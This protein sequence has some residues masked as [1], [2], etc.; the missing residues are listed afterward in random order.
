MPLAHAADEEH[1][2]VHGQAEQDPHQQDGEEAHDGSGGGEHHQSTEVALLEDPDDGPEGR[3]DGEQEP[4]HGLERDQHRPEDDGQDQRGEAHDDEQVQR[5][6]GTELGGDV[7]V[8]RR[9][10]RHVDLGTVGGRHRGGPT[11][12]LGHE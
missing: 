6:G 8:H 4:E 10:A 5:Q 1:L 3:A 12:D 7:D 9:W 2:V 11:A